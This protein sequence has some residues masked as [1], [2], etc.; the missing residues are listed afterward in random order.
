M[1]CSWPAAQTVGVVRL[2][3][4]R[5]GRQQ[6][7][8]SHHLGVTSLAF[9]PDGKLLLSASRDGDARLWDVAERRSL[10]ILDWHFGPLGGASF[11][12]DGRWIV[13]AGPSSAA[14][15]SVATG[16]R[17]LLLNAG[18]TRPLVGAAFGGRDGRVIVTASKDGTIRTYRCDVCGGI[19]ELVALAKRRLM[20]P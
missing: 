16:R 6:R 12:P 13:T 17:V 11:S 4:L 19:D 8:P 14:V 1:A 9:S 20:S 5:T 7:I 3:N 18:R 10:Y 2:W 15:G